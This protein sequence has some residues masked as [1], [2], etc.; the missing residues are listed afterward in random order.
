MTVMA[1]PLCLLIYGNE[2]AG[3]L[4]Q[5]MAPF[6]LLWYLQ[7]PFAAVLQGLDRAKEAMRNSIFGAL[8]KAAL[9]FILG[10]QPALGIDGVV[11]A[12][13]T[14]IV[15]VT[16]LHMATITRLV[17]F[18][19]DVRE[20]AKILLAM[21]ITGWVAYLGMTTWFTSY[22]IGWAVPL[23]L[24]LSGVIYLFCV[25]LLRLL[26]QDDV[27]QIPYVGKYLAPLFPK[28]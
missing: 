12:L 4:M 2:E 15:V 6:T 14:G 5:L 3:R 21:L 24:L 11:I 17:S 27:V 28:H 25:V 19:F 8:V 10:S 26:V 23:C 22:G 20:I 7:G 16:V 13:N 9:I 18:T 1:E